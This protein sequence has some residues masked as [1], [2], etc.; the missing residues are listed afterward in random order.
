MLQWGGGQRGGDSPEEDVEAVLV[1][2][3]HVITTASDCHSI[4]DDTSSSTVGLSCSA[5][6]C[7]TLP[8]RLTCPLPV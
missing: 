4:N 3:R 7:A 1:H 6:E 5:R 2:R 8:A